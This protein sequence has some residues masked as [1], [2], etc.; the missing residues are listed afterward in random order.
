MA[1]WGKCD[2]AEFRAMADRFRNAVEIKASE[3]FTREVLQELGNML[4]RRTKRRT[5]VK[6]GELRRKWFITSVR[7]R[8]D[9]F[10]IEIYNNTEY[11]PWVENG[12][13]VVKSGNTVGWSEG[14][15]MMRLS[16]MEIERLAPEVIG[17]RSRQFVRRLLEGGA[18][19]D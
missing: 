7:Q 15:F 2:F 18:A 1:S 13:R 3:Q 19:H 9:V 12:H 6:S 16:L 11:A 5:P 14:F 17:K 4:L 10:E 8:D